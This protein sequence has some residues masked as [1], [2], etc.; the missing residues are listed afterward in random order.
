MSR[1]LYIISYG[2]FVSQFGLQYEVLGL[3]QKVELD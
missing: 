2:L 1:H 3:L